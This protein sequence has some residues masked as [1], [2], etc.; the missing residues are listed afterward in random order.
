MNETDHHNILERYNMHQDMS[1]DK[2]APL[3]AIIL[4]IIIVL[5]LFIAVLIMLF[6]K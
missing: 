4:I 5:L 6:K 1:A 2:K 3:L